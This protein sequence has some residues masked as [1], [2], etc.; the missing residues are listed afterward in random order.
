MGNFR[1][2]NRY[3]EYVYTKTSKYVI[4]LHRMLTNCPKGMEV[5]HI[6]ANGLDNR[7]E[8]LRHV[9]KCRNI[10]N[11]KIRSN[12]RTGVNGVQFHQKAYM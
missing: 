2:H 10:Q 12:N 3:T 9:H 1:K 8:N 11:G 6:N 4:D 7:K 5:D